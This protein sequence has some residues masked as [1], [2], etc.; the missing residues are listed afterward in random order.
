MR[1]W[2]HRHKMRMTT[3]QEFWWFISALSCDISAFIQDLSDISSAMDKVCHDPK[4]DFKNLT[5][6]YDCCG[7]WLDR[8]EQFWFL[9]LLPI[10]VSVDKWNAWIS[11]L[12]V[13]SIFLWEIIWSSPYCC[14]SVCLAQVHYPGYYCSKSP[15]GWTARGVDLKWKYWWPWSQKYITKKE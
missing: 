2:K 15:Q 13:I 14:G 7:G 6:S 8:E 11:F 4:A 1:S 5:L 10:W 3:S 12:L 9:F